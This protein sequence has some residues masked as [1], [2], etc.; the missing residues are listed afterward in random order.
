MHVCVYIYI[1]DGF[2]AEHS[3][4]RS[5]MAPPAAAAPCSRTPSIPRLRASRCAQPQI[6]AI[7]RLGAL[8]VPRLLITTAWHRG[9]ADQLPEINAGICLPVFVR[10]IPGQLFSQSP[11]VD[12]LCSWWR[13]VQP[14]TTE[15]TSVK[16]G[17]FPP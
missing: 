7:R 5:Q 16:Q 10:K 15:G 3:L 17:H 14:G 9:P 4:P 11:R 13:R 6:G 2:V 12:L 8:P 1:R